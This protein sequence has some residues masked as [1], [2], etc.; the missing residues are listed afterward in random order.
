V[1]SLLPFLYLEPS[2]V[3]GLPIQLIGTERYLSSNWGLLIGVLHSRL[4]RI[5]STLITMD[6]NSRLTRDMKSNKINQ[7]ICIK[8]KKIT[9]HITH[10]FNLMATYL[11]S[12]YLTTCGWKG[13]LKLRKDF[14]TETEILKKEIEIFSMLITKKIIETLDA[15]RSWYDVH[16][17]AAAEAEGE[18]G[19]QRQGGGQGGGQRQGGEG[20]GE[21][22]FMKMMAAL[23]AHEEN[24]ELEQEEQEREAIDKKYLE[25]KSHLPRQR[26]GISSGDS[27]NG[28]RNGIPYRERSSVVMRDRVGM[29]LDYYHRLYPNK[30]FCNL[31]IQ[32]CLQ[33]ISFHR[34]VVDFIDSIVEE[35]EGWSHPDGYRSVAEKDKDKETLNLHSEKEKG[36]DNSLTEQQSQQQQQPPQIE[37]SSVTSLSRT[38]DTDSV[39]EAMDN[40]L[41]SHYV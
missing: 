23:S 22:D 40:P 20:E 33:T 15:K 10:S 13:N 27:S 6:S 30:T 31:A 39:L 7:D 14:I 21:G 28:S 12:P 2:W 1:S 11:E 41:L 19:G 18:G 36:Q 8:M 38:T 32:V 16:Q 37:L 9:E 29:T 34:E 35:G 3:P 17:E 5:R 26:K 4:T 25:E 24:L